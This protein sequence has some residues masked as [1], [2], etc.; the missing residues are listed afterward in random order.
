[1]GVVG[2]RKSSQRTPYMETRSGWSA[3]RRETTHK[4]KVSDVL[5]DESLPLY[6]QSDGVLQVGAERKHRGGRQG[7]DGAGA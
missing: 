2:N 1:M 6:H 4:V 5:A 7:G 3:R